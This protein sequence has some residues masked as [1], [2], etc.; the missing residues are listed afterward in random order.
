M[1]VDVVLRLVAQAQAEKEAVAYVPVVL[2]KERAVEEKNARQRILNDGRGILRWRGR[3][4][5]RNGREI[6]AAVFPSG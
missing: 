3:L 1:V 4:I 6:V 2:R 5:G